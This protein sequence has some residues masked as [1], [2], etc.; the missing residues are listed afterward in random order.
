MSQSAL[1]KP[2]KPENAESPENCTGGCPR[3]PLSETGEGLDE[4]TAAH[5][6]AAG[7]DLRGFDLLGRSAAAFVLPVIGALVGAVLAGG[8][9]TQRFAG[10][11]AGLLVAT[12]AGVTIMGVVRRYA[13]KE[14]Q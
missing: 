6:V 12:L 10:M 5:N 13:K 3:C 8:S 2:E 14:L 1:E 7:G 9:E 4:W 11:V